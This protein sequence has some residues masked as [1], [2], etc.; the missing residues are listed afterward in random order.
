M[1]FKISRSASS[2]EIVSIDNGNKQFEKNIT[3][4]V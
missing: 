4:T 2:K 3:K 1:D